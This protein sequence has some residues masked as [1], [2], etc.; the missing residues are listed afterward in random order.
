MTLFLLNVIVAISKVWRLSTILE[1]ISIHLIPIKTIMIYNCKGSS[2]ITI[3]M[4]VY[5][6]LK[7]RIFFGK[8]EIYWTKLIIQIRKIIFF[9]INLF[10]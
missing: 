5:L 8:L 9:L 6:N 2:V 10:L 3:L 4:V 1:Q 7:F